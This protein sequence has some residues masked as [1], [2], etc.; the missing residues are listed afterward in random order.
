MRVYFMCVLTC[1]SF[2]IYVAP[3]KIKIEGVNIFVKVV[4]LKIEY[5]YKLI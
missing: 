1:R 2:G 3:F 4:S 5:S